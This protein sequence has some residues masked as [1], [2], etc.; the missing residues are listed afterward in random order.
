M[1]PKGRQPAFVSEMGNIMA[2]THQ[3][4]IHEVAIGGVC[5]CPIPRC[6]KVKQV[7]TLLEPR[8]SLPL[9]QSRLLNGLVALLQQ[10]YT[11][12]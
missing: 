2:I 5:T 12:R 1:L 3:Y 6:F 10:P 4:G 11:I 9:L 7:N 8:Q